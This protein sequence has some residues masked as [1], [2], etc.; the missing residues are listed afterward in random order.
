MRSPSR[1]LALLGS[2]ALFLSLALS[3]LA[4]SCS[5]SL[6][7]N[8]RVKTPSSVRDCFYDPSMAYSN[9]SALQIIS[10]L[11]SFLSFYSFVDAYKE[12]GSPF[13]IT[14]DIM[15]K[16]DALETKA[17]SGAYSW[18]YDF[19]VDVSNLV[20]SLKD[21]HTGYS[22]PAGFGSFLTV[23]P[24]S[25]NP[26]LSGSSLSLTV[27]GTQVA[28]AE[29]YKA[30]FGDDLSELEGWTVQSIAG[31][32]PIDWMKTFAND[33]FPLAKDPSIN[34]NCAVLG[35]FGYPRFNAWNPGKLK[36]S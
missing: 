11:R 16:L 20:A 3:A 10:S 14:F 2:L 18:D 35:C 21:G 30:L 34:F 4:A 6:T 24:I 25:L 36:I 26:T 7:P 1:A 32:D 9:T 22:F 23:I 19:H 31:T 8:G 29:V 13:N 12:T 5:D 33:L 15:A 27:S 17:L 28:T